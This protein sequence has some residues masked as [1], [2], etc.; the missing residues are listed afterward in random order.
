MSPIA[1]LAISVPDDSTNI[2]SVPLRAAD[3]APDDELS[4]PA[5]VLRFITSLTDDDTLSPGDR[6]TGA[7]ML[8]YG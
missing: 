5:P 8:T 6:L 1:G 4:C 3:T 7:L 2:S